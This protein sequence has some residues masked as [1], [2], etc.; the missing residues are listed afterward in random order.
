MSL[1]GNISCVE[2][3]RELL[4]PSKD[5]TVMKK[6]FG[7]GFWNFCEPCHKWNSFRPFWPT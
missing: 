6:K 5:S 1:H 4:E 3:A 7:F 2:S